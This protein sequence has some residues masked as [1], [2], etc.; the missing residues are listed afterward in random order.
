MDR[1]GMG[2]RL[3]RPLQ[4]MAARFPRTTTRR[5]RRRLLG[6]RS[7]NFAPHRLTDKGT[8]MTGPINERD[9]NDSV[10]T[11]PDRPRLVTWNITTLDGRIAVSGSTPAWLDERW[12]PARRD[13]EYVDIAA[14]HDATVTL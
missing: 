4:P 14:F 12:A 6:T 10:G 5:P 2:S 8:M 3:R 9:R 7:R 11:E 1:S 13:F